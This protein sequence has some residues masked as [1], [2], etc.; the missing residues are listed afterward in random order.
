[1]DLNDII[2]FDNKTLADLAKEVYTTTQKKNAKMEK[3]IDDLISRLKS[4]S[5]YAALGMSLSEMFK[6]SINNDDKLLRL[7]VIV[8]RIVK[9]TKVIN[10]VGTDFGLSEEEKSQLLEEAQKLMDADK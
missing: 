8:Q 4:D 9:E 6:N 3:V 5:S 2:L 7:A 1:M 10:N